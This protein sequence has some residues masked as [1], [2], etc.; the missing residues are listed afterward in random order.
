MRCVP[1]RCSDISLR[2]AAWCVRR[3]SSEREAR[4]CRAEFD[5]SEQLQVT[6]LQ[7]APCL[8]PSA[9]RCAID[10]MDVVRGWGRFYLKGPRVGGG[11]ERAIGCRSSCMAGAKLVALTRVD[12]QLRRSLVQILLPS[13]FSDFS[14]ISGPMFC[15]RSSTSAVRLTVFPSRSYAPISGSHPAR[16]CSAATTTW[17]ARRRIT[18]DL[19]TEGSYVIKLYKFTAEIAP[20]EVR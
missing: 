17:A 8:H 10:A 12:G 18:T 19:G 7:C 16:C 3:R 1:Q 11:Q 4:S 5:D 20:V 6:A 14:G 9:S 15:A 13:F 2:L